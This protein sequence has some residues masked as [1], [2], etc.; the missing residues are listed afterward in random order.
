MDVSADWASASGSG[1]IC[2]GRLHNLGKNSPS[3]ST[4]VHIGHHSALP[5]V[6]V[7]NDSQNGVYISHLLKV[8]LMARLVT[9]VVNY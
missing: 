9:T 3:P 2:E 1:F 8:R 6:D 5:I 4:F 7:H